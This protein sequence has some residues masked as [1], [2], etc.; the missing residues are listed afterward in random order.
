M[1]GPV[2]IQAQVESGHS[3]AEEQIDMTSGAGVHKPITV[4]SLPS[5][6]MFR[7]ALITL[8]PF[9]IL[10]QTSLNSK[11]QDP[12]SFRL[13]VRKRGSRELKLT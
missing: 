13:D 1:I 7:W 2:P 12:S 8:D 4:R 6:P 9:L 11:T 5:L 10:R 3:R